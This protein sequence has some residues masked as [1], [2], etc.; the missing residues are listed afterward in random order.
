MA[1]YRLLTTFIVKTVA[2]V[3][4]LQAYASVNGFIYFVR[5][6]G[7]M[8]GSPVGGKILGESVLKNYRGVILFDAA[9]LAGAMFCVIAVRFFDSVEKRSWKWRA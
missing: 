2:E 6:L 7:T 9:L 5:G 4:G 3:F 8:F 1:R